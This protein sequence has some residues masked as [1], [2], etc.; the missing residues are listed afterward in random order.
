[1]T[2][3]GVAVCLG[4]VNLLVVCGNVFVLY[5][6]ISQ[7]SLHTST[8]FI[9]LSLTVSDFALGVIVL[10]FSIFQEYSDSWMFGAVWCKTWL[11]LDVLFSTAS[12]YNLLAISFDRYM[13]VRQPIKYRFISSNR[14]TKITIAVV[15]LISAALAF[16][17]LVYD[18]FGQ[19]DPS[20]HGNWSGI[21]TKV[22]PGQ[23]ECTPMT[24]NNL[25]I[26]FSAFVSF[27]LPMFLMIGL[28]LSIFHT[29][30]DSTK[31]TKIKSNGT[32]APSSGN[33]C[34]DDN[35]SWMR[36][37]RGG[38]KSSV[39]SRALTEVVSVTPG[40][41]SVS[42]SVGSVKKVSV[43]HQNQSVTRPRP[44]GPPT[45]KTT[46]DF[47]FSLDRD[48]MSLASTDTGALLVG[49]NMDPKATWIQKMKKTNLMDRK[50]AIVE[51]D[52]VSYY[53]M[54]SQ[55]A[56]HS[57]P[58][59]LYPCQSVI[60]KSVDNVWYPAV[61]TSLIAGKKPSKKQSERLLLYPMLQLNRI[62]LRTE[63]RV[64]RTIGVV[65]GCFT[66]CWLPFT[67]IYILQ[68]FE[69][70]PVGICVPPWM[71]TLA[72]WLGYANSALNPLLYAA[73]SR[74]FRSAF[75]KVLT[76]RNSSFRSY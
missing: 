36:V 7:K 10:P 26:L 18:H 38:A 37:H 72:F 23:G 59:T 14:M 74:D 39:C 9:V 11:A 28:N 75:K 53:S 61:I 67:I 24:S 6:L 21:N 51:A 66:V 60:Q 30:N 12:I 3:F 25:Y 15:W 43:M 41:R 22:V 57:T 2:P 63:L 42:M 20:I 58:A 71:F 69:T 35:N 46:F 4:V 34:N 5:I 52:R 16:P 54:E 44:S 19:I 56:C 17:P 29:V 49:D 70:C 48:T 33:Y 31:L 50:Q 64:A 32:P 76:D 40:Q 1:M 55:P 65:V 45:R 73:F 13:A 8:N 62:S 47:G 68:A 27:V